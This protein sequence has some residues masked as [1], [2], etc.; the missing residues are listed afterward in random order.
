[1][2]TEHKLTLDLPAITTP[3]E[4]ETQS[5]EKKTLQIAEIK[6]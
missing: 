3:I 4:R 6:I 5:S 2:A 1:M